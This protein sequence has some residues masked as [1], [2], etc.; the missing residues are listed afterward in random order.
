[1]ES[2]NDNPTPDRVLKSP[3]LF[4]V[5]IKDNDSLFEKSDTFLSYSD[6]SLPKFKT[7]S[8]HTKATSSGSTT[9]YADN[10]FP[11]YDSFLFEIEPDQGE[12]T[13]V[14]MEDIL[15]EP[16]VH[17][18]CFDI[19]EKNSGSTTIDAD[20]SL[21]DLECFY[22]KSEPDPRD[23]TSIIDPEIRE[24]VS[25]MTNVNSPFEDDQSPIF[26]YVV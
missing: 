17:I 19:E 15:G 18:F 23:F 20:I 12:L 8:D 6:N 9:T 4:L 1:I 21:L 11:K 5:P 14:V 2:L 13:S 10:S 24:N 22:F 3:S 25:P 7:F 26:A 16:R